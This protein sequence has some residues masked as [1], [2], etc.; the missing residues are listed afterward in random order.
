MSIDQMIDALVGREGGYSLN[1]NDSGGATMWGVTADT[2]RRN[3]YQGAMSQMPRETAVAIYRSEYFTA[4]GFDK[5]YDLSQPIAEEL[6]DTGVNL[7]LSIPTPWLQRALNAL[8][9][10]HTDYPDI[11][12]DGRI[13]PQT[14]GALRVYLNLRGADGERNVLKLLNCLQ[15]VHYLDI[16]EARPA[17]EAFINGWLINRVGII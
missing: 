2:A 13:G 11:P 14:V 16:T 1:P 10:Q 6:F 9:R 5:V 4:P 15:G 17:N 3:G 12:V 8:N 7:G